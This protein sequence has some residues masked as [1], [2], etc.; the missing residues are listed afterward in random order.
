MNTGHARDAC[1]LCAPDTCTCLLGLC[2]CAD[3][4]LVNEHPI[5]KDASRTIKLDRTSAMPYHRAPGD[6][7]RA[8]KMSARSSRSSGAWVPL[9]VHACQCEY[10]ECMPLP[11]PAMV[12]GRGS[13]ETV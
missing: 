12:L 6:L 13:S 2:A 7:G 5:H 9:S 8:S 11:A 4:T 3:D 1:V 10:L